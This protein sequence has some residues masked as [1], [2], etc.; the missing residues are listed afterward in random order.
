MIV[1]R[2]R[3]AGVS[4]SVVVALWYGRF[5]F[6]GMREGEEGRHCFAEAPSLPL[7]QRAPSLTANGPSLTRVAA[8]PLVGDRQR[9]LARLHEVKRAAPRREV[10]RQ[11]LLEVAA[12]HAPQRGRRDDE[13]RPVV[14][15]ARDGDDRLSVMS[16]FL[17]L[18]RCVSFWC[19]ACV[20]LCTSMH[21][22]GA[23]F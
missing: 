20:C 4:A 17:G 14:G 3:I 12:P 19:G 22:L 13:E 2:R 23:G 7:P 10:G 21:A 18:F 15:V 9:L 1:M 8:G 16:V 5:V 11:P 6:G